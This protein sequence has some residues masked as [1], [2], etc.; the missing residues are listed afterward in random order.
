MLLTT[1]EFK[2]KTLGFSFNLKAQ[3]GDFIL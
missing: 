1:D 2:L 3:S